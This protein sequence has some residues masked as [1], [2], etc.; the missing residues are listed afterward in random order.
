LT[1]GLQLPKPGELIGAKYLVERLL[2]LG[3]MG[4][5]YEAKHRVTGK[6][7]ALKLL[8]PE[9]TMRDD[10]V[11]RFIREAQVAG[12]FQHPNVV[13]V[14]DIGEHGA[15]FFMVME[16]LHGESLALRLER[17]ER[18]PVATACQ[19]M[20]QCLDALAAAHGA[21][22]IHRDL[23]PANIFLCEARRGE[24]LAKVLDFGISKLTDLPGIP[25]ATT[26]DT[27]TVMGTP[28]YMAPEQL[29]SRGVDHRVDIYALGVTLYQLLS[30]RQPYIA[31]NYPDLVIKIWTETP[32]SLEVLA[33]D[34]P[35]ELADV[36]ARAMAR[37]ADDRF[38][39]AEAMSR[40]LEPFASGKFVSSPRPRP[41]AQG[42]GGTLVAPASDAP[43]AQSPFRVTRR[44]DEDLA[45]DLRA[46]SNSDLLAAARASSDAR[47]ASGER[48]RLRSSAPAPRVRYQPPPLPAAANAA[49]RGSV[50]PASS[51][52][53]AAVPRSSP[54]GSNRDAHVASSAAS[55]RRE[56][57]SLET[58]L[59]TSTPFASESLESPRSWAGGF[60]S[61][62]AT[63]WILAACALAIAVYGIWRGI[64]AE[65]ASL[66]AA[67][68]VPEVQQP[69]V[70]VAQPV[71]PNPAAAAAPSDTGS[72]VQPPPRAESTATP[73]GDL[74]S[75]SNPAAA[76]AAEP[77]ELTKQAP[78]ASPAPPA[79]Q[80]PAR[81]PP[82]AFAAPGP[83]RDTA[84]TRSSAARVG[85]AAALSDPAR[86]AQP[87][88]AARRAGDDAPVEEDAADAVKAQ[89]FQ[90]PNPAIDR[91]QF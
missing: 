46:S 47:D 39:D 81:R 55:R 65:E 68:P 61:G 90:R 31:D 78:E 51:A 34:T 76:H 53:V 2:G 10:V 25:K 45:G 88:A 56:G 12:R 24:T 17:V 84:T 83:P 20:M 54:A 60:W 72:A 66:E 40:A 3:G 50:R 58:T 35:A 21:G 32:P 69:S 18:L 23:K 87:S 49:V 64:W 28:F 27:G 13:E 5:V 22:I 29:R 63:R 1:E 16:L 43:L 85:E 14:Y 19:L 33:P 26:T 71:A 70:T 77:V 75:G 41:R 48:S 52:P 73:D 62:P 59:R 37:S 8:L 91:T 30:G 80:S 38:A 9:L 67:R 86:A 11:K 44:V 15:S 36:V 82:A 6:H 79:V 74:A 89:P 42:A 4:A 57:A 7:F